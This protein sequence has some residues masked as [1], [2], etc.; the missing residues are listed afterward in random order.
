V[1]AALLR[2]GS[3]GA[4]VGGGMMEK[5]AMLRK[6]FDD[7]RS[8]EN[9]AV[10]LAIGKEHVMLSSSRP[11]IVKASALSRQAAAAGSGACANS[12]SAGAR[13]LLGAGEGCE[14]GGGGGSGVGGAKGCSSV[15]REDYGLCGPMTRE[16]IS[17][18]MCEEPRMHQRACAAAVFE[19]VDEERNAGVAL[20]SDTSPTS[21]RAVQQLQQRDRVAAVAA[22]A[23]REPRLVPPAAND[24]RLMTTARGTASTLKIARLQ[25]REF[26]R[27]LS[28]SMPSSRYSF[29]SL[30]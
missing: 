5:L 25:V 8:A 2:C 27:S 7:K 17:L 28:A 10:C 11:L 21:E 24:E 6:E 12:S 15:L 14:R 3:R 22:V 26:A 29:Y 30:Y 13:W 23:A 20:A 9:G 16:A 1:Y 18:Q 19:A 4:R